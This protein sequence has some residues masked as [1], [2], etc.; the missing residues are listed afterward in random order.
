LLEEQKEEVLRLMDLLF[1]A[2]T[3]SLLLLP[4]FAYEIIAKKSFCSANELMFSFSV[5]FRNLSSVI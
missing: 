4:F 1:Y 5:K 3:G 2:K